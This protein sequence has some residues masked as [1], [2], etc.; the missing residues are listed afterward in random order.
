MKHTPDEREVLLLEALRDLRGDLPAVDEKGIC[1]FC[2]RDYSD[3]K[4]VRERTCLSDDCPSFKADEL[5]AQFESEGTA[6]E[7]GA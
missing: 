2:G 3:D 6:S 5:L 7:G 1:R 4:E